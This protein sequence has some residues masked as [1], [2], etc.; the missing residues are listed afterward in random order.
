[1]ETIPLLFTLHL[2]LHHALKKSL[3]KKLELDSPLQ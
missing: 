2:L 1:M 3:L